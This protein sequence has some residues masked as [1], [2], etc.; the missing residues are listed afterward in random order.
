MQSLL[1]VIQNARVVIF[2]FLLFC[3]LQRK[4]KKH[5]EEK[6]AFIVISVFVILTSTSIM[7]SLLLRLCIVRHT[8]D[9]CDI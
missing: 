9:R 7:L 1:L 4:K 2:R 6:K 3:D 5:K 8:V